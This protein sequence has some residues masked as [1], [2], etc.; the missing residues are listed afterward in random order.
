MLYLISSNRHLENVIQI[1]TSLIIFIIIFIILNL[2]FM[3]HGG[4]TVIKDVTL[5]SWS[6]ASPDPQQQML[7]NPILTLVTLASSWLEPLSTFS[8]PHFK[9]FIN[10]GIT[11]VFLFFPP[12]A[13]KCLGGFSVSARVTAQL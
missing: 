13:A 3:E 10:R 5:E 8:Y 4:G 1:L 12:F 9:L 11:D 2:K 6:L 7:Y